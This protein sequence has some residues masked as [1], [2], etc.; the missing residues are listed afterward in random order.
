MPLG[1]ISPVIPHKGCSSRFIDFGKRIE[2]P[3]S[4][5]LKILHVPGGN[6]EVMPPRNRCDVAI[7]NRH[8]FARRLELVLQFRPYVSG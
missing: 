6:R 2:N 7:F 4:G 5:S 3:N 8:W 1:Q